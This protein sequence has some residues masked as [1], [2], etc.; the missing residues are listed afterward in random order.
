MLLQHAQHHQ[1]MLRI[2]L[3]PPPIRSP[4]TVCAH[5]AMV[6]AVGEGGGRARHWAVVS[7]EVPQQRPAAM[8]LLMAF[9]VTS[10]TAGY[11]VDTD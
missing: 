4:T 1:I 6:A 7:G 9:F 8:I 5:A 10:T 2:S 3:A 11:M